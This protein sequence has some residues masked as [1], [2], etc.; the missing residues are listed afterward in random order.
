[1]VERLD[2][3]AHM[4][5]RNGTPPQTPLRETC[6]DYSGTDELEQALAGFRRN[7]VAEGWRIRDCVLDYMVVEES[8]TW[9]HLSTR[10]PKTEGRF[11]HKTE[12]HIWSLALV[13]ISGTMR[14]YGMSL[15]W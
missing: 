4:S 8:R 2:L 15:R 13:M 7:P 11:S 6:G 14:P 12:E 5:S 3:V 9:F 1:M 10:P